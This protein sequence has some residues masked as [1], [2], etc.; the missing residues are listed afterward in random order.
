MFRNTEKLFAQSALRAALALIVL[1]GLIIAVGC[2]GGGS[3]VTAGPTPTPSTSAG[4]SQVRFGDAPADSVIQFEVTVSALSLTPAG[5]GAD[6]SVTVPA[7]NRIELTHASG[8]FEPFVTGN[9]PQGTFSAVKMTLANS[10]LTFLTSTGTPVHF[11]GPASASISVPLSPNLTIGTSPMV[12]NIDV[13]IAN[14]VSLTGS[15]I[16]GISFGS[17]SFNITAKAPGAQNAQQDDDG[18]IEDVQ[19]KVTAVNG[20]SFTMTVGQTGSSLTFATDSTTQFKDGVT[21]LASALNQVV[22]VEGFTRADGSLFAK[23][24]EGLESQTG[25]EMEG[26][27][28][29]I[30]GSTLTVN[31]Q[32]GIGN[33]MDDTKMGAS[34]T[35]NIAGL[36]A[37]KFRVK[38]GNGFGGSLPNA[39][40]PFD[41][42]TIHV[43][44]RIEVDSDAAMPAANGSIS[45]DKINLQQQGISGTVSNNAASSFDVTLAADS[46]LAVLSGQT[47]V[48]VTKV[49]GTDSRTNPSNGGSVRV[50]GLLFWNG[51]SWQM[52]ARRIQ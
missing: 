14:S 33:G 5:G 44:Q 47:V 2:G 52:I 27:I 51:T 13:N 45:V 40:F 17:T 15:T 21:T 23:E 50:R 28:T 49:S 19:G 1:A 22:T 29:A 32:D 25:S 34:F 42:T 18:E 46:A 7:N 11:N 8:K 39:T 41:G 6:V 12:F 38:T 37:S 31:A 20:S 43:G 10:E 35:V 36:N 3:S 4:S 16:T 30:S 26:L 24:V 48:H 9:L